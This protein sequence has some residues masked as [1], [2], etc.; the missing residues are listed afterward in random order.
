MRKYLSL[1]YF[2]LFVTTISQAQVDR[3]KAPAPGPA[4]EIKIGEY[5]SFTL[6]NGL[7]VFVVENDKLPSVSFS[8]TLDREPI[9]EGDKAGY[10]AIAGLMLAHGTT[11]RSKAQLDEE[12]DFIGA[13]LNTSPT[14]IFASSLSRHKEKLLEL[15][16]DVLFNPAFPPDEFDKIVKQ[17]KSALAANKEDPGAIMSDVRSV[18]LYGKDH[19]Y[20]E[21]TTESTVDNLTVDDCKTYYQ[22]YFKPNIGYLAV[23]GDISFNQSKTLITKYFGGWQK[24]AVDKPAY[25]IP[26]PP[27]QTFVALVDR[28]G[29][30]QSVLSITYPVVLKP[31]EP[32]V[33]RARLLN[34]ILGGSFSSRLMQNLREDK[35]Y[36][37][38]ARS[39]LS[40]DELVGSFAA[41][42][43]V[44][45][46]VTDSA[47]H[48]FLYELKKMRDDGAQEQELK[49]AKAY[50]IGS[51]ARSLEQPQTIANFAI[52]T[53]RYNL[54]E[55][56]YQNYLKNLEMV[57]IDDIRSMAEKY[58]KP[59]NAYIIAVGK[60]Q[61]IAEKLERFGRVKYYNIYGEHYDPTQAKLP[62]GLTAAQVIDNYI[63]ALGGKDNLAKVNTLKTTMK[64][65]A[66][67]QEME[68]IDIR[69]KGMR[70]RKELLAGGNPFSQAI[71]NGEDAVVI[72]MGQ[73]STLDE[74]TKEE[75]II[76]NALFPELQYEKLGVTINL[77][78]TDKIEGND[79]Y[80]LE[81]TLPSGG[82]FTEYFDARSGLKLRYVKTL[83][84]PQGSLTQT[85]DFADYKEVEGILFPHSF[86]QRVGPQNITGVVSN[87]EVNGDVDEN[88]FKVE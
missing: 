23:V 78:G 70:S 3:S 84:T 28:P 36:T 71:S 43:N 88:A 35:G 11:S 65:T 45:N 32:D 66:M 7:K 81:V 87:V 22:K 8:L 18:L 79:V 24:G 58:I 42:A 34:Q 53:A 44:R 82:K 40:S 56:Y 52:N 15:M 73:K 50:I 14:G 6:P 47:V 48:E 30:V 16:T 12:I 31:G 62:D 68:I 9:M 4:P 51:F 1:L 17:T 76:T 26:N 39:S 59:D 20:G 41:S 49:S 64:A 63:M 37:Y 74:K 5:Q 55:D 80:T 83:E 13:S 38:G 25:E 10:V 61:D 75:Q 85:I 29:A 46:E 2:S 67:G 54:P 60:A 27:D 19:P 69:A 57:T 77:A 33:I 21:L 72:Q 86:S